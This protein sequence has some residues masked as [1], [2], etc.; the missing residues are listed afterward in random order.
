ML[1][2]RMKIRTLGPLL[3]KDALPLSYIRVCLVT[4][5]G[6]Y[7]LWG[8][9]GQLLRPRLDDGPAVPARP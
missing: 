8:P 3:G 4:G 7:A 5:Q 1:S 2:K 6:N 9:N